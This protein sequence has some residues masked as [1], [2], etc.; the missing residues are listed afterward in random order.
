MRVSQVKSET[1]QAYMKGR[2]KKKKQI[3]PYR[4]VAILNNKGIYL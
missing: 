3:N 1:R 2:E 4:S